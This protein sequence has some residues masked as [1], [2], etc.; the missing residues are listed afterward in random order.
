MTRSEPLLSDLRGREP[1]ALLSLVTF[2]MVAAAM[3]ALGGGERL[4]ATAT[5]RCS[6][7]RVTPFSRSVARRVRVQRT[8][9]SSRKRRFWAF[10]T[11]L[12]YPPRTVGR[13]RAQANLRQTRVAPDCADR[14][15][16]RIL[17]DAPDCGQLSFDRLGW[18]PK[19][20]LDLRGLHPEVKKPMDGHTAARISFRLNDALRQRGETLSSRIPFLPRKEHFPLR[21]GVPKELLHCLVDEL[22]R[23]A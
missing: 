15:G 2:H 11:E 21:R 22:F 18:P 9:C 16:L 23:P 7:V 10:H 17:L 13:L 5:F 12:C 19:E 14:R 6:T 1:F 20:V 3:L 4:P 8:P